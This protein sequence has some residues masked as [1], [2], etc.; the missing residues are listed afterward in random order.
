MPYKVEQLL[1]EPIIL[2]TISGTATPEDAE[3][4]LVEVKKLLDKQTSRVI[5]IIDFTSISLNFNDIIKGSNQFARGNDPV[6]HHPMLGEL[7][8]VTHEKLIKMTAK[9]MD[10][11]PFGHVKIAVFES[12]DDALVHT[13]SAA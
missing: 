9:G 5:H 12:L 11:D 6:F 1:N 2:A 3:A 7:I 4:T 10:S 13:R 8:F